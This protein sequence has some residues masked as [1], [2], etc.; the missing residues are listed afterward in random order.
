[1]LLAIVDSFRLLWPERAW[2]GADTSRSCKMKRDHA[3][4]IYMQGDCEDEPPKSLTSKLQ[5]PDLV[6]LKPRQCL[7]VLDSP[8]LS[9]PDSYDGIWLDNLYLRATKEVFGMVVQLFAP[10]ELYLTDCTFQGPGQG[11]SGSGEAGSNRGVVATNL[12]SRGALTAR[13]GAVI[14]VCCD[15]CFGVFLLMFI[16]IGI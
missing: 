5:S 9:L 15:R 14:D 6:G 8:L 10:S 4:R 11:S 12:Y 7:L 2:S 13:P 3:W 1:M 16:V